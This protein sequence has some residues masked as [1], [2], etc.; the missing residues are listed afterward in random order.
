MQSRYTKHASILYTHVEVTAVRKEVSLEFG[1][2][3]IG[4]LPTTD[5]FLNARGHF[6]RTLLVGGGIARHGVDC[7]RAKLWV[8]TLQ[9]AGCR[10]S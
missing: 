2:R 6:S 10:M 1:G 8:P 3:V 7:C 4:R 9:E 5:E